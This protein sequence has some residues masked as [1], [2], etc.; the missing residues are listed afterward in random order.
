MYRVFNQGK[1]VGDYQN[2]PWVGTVSATK[3]RLIYNSAIGTWHRQRYMSSEL[4]PIEKVPK[5]YLV[6]NLILEMVE[7]HD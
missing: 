2:F 5:E 3:T 1:H 6:L 7:R 4:V